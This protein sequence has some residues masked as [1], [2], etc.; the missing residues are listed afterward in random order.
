M[1]R[2]RDGLIMQRTWKFRL[3]SLSKGA[4]LAQSENRDEGGGVEEERGEK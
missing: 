1:R 4:R 3:S 2:G